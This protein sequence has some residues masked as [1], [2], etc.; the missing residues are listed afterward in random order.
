MNKRILWLLVSASAILLAL[1][2][3]IDGS[4]P[5]SAQSDSSSTRIPTTQSESMGSWQ[6]VWRMEGS[7]YDFQALDAHTVLGA[8]AN[9][10]IVSSTDGGEYWHYTAPVD[11]VD[12]RAIAVSANVIWVA[13]DQGVILKS[14]DRGKTWEQIDAETT[15]AINDIAAIGSTVSWIVGDNGMMMHSED[16]GVNWSSATSGVTSSLNAIG[17]FDD[18]MHGIS[19]G[20]GGVILL[21]ADGGDAWQQK[22]GVAP[23][24]DDLKDIHI[25]G[26]KVWAVGSAGRIYASEDMGSTWQVQAS[27][28]FPMTRITMAPGQDQIGWIVGLDGRIART[29]NGGG[30]W[31]ANSGDEGYHLYALAL[32]D[33]D[34]V[35]TGGYVMRKSIYGWG[36]PPDKPSWFVWRS[37]NG[38][39]NWD[40]PITGLYPWFYNVTAVTDQD[41]YVTGQDLQIMK[42]RDGGYSWREIHSEL[43]SNPEIAPPNTDIRGLIFHGIS[44]APGDPEDCHAA[45]RKA[46]LVHTTDGGDTWS[47]EYIAG[48]GKAIYDIEMTSAESGVAVCRNYNYFTDDGFTW[49]GA[50]DNGTVRTHLDVDMIN[51]WQG[52]VS[53]KKSLFNY[54]LDAGRHWKG[55][56]FSAPGRGS[57]FYNSGVDTMDVNEDGDFDNTWLVGCSEAF[58]DGPCVEA[59][60]LFNPDALHPPDSGVDP[61]RGWRALLADENV[62]RLQKVEMVNE[63]EGWV[64]GYDATVLFTEDAGITWTKQGVPTDANLYGLDVFNRDL[65]Y[66][67]GLRGDIIRYSEP[68]RRLSANPQWLNQIDGNLEEWNTLN[69]RNIN[70]EDVDTIIG[71]TPDP[72]ALDANVRIRWDDRG[73]YLGINVTDATLTTSGD[74]IDALGV[75]LD[76]RGDGVI[77]EDDHVLMF[78]ADGHA[79]LD[80]LAMAPTDFGIITTAEGYDIEAFLPKDMLGDDFEHLR[81]LGINVGLYDAAP[82]S[83]SYISQLFWTGTELA[84]D[85]A[86]FGVLTLFQFDRNHPT[87]TALATDELVI[88]GDLGDWTDDNTYPLTSGTADSIQGE[89]PTDTSDLSADFRMRWWDDYLFF[90]ISVSDDVVMEGDSV[91]LAFDVTKDS[92]LSP[93]DLAFR[94][95]P[96]GRVTTNGVPGGEILARGQSTEDGYQLEIALPATIL[97]GNFSPWQK[98]HFNYGLLDFDTTEDRF[99]TAMNW[100]G[101]SVAGVEAD[102]GWLE[103]SPLT[104]LF[105]SERADPLVHDTF[106]KEWNPDTNYD[107]SPVMNIRIDGIESPLI[108][109]DIDSLLPENARLTYAILGLYT[110]D[111]RGGAAFMARIYRMLRPWVAYEATWNRAG[112]NQAW[113]IP[114]AKGASDQAQSPTDEKKL[115]PAGVDG[116]CGDRNA[117]WFD[118]TGDVSDFVSGA[119]PNNGWILRGDAGANINYNL[120]STQNA[121]P[122]CF[123]EMYFEYTYPSGV[124]PS[125]TPV[126]TPTPA[127]MRLYLPLIAP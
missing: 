115:A 124:L 66:A 106:I 101:A 56:Y 9:G 119:A 89:F 44:C 73:L 60:I 68:D 108:R 48:W 82:D 87:Q 6:R 116:S 32:G 27:L 14:Q 29:S 28:G 33:D 24:T 51:S 52:A 103:L 5:S 98:L 69:S 46:L 43:T 91:L 112:T 77:G 58:Q 78:Y 86:T 107:R 10:M 83:T 39:A 75:A 88:D 30:S 23:V 25:Y 31:S 121:N 7:L 105:K 114:G 85:P 18:G 53:T 57:F 79:L 22:T 61:A 62:A 72:A 1:L 102:F 81:K 74:V 99:D 34:H 3:L 71:A 16:G 92:I 76:G 70:S 111:D 26:D 19:V 122:D 41:A 123:P 20:D 118:V 37:E 113:E 59:L 126:A 55:Y 104:L 93:Q 65:A 15:E 90:G 17:L 64:V 54:T 36:S 84:G 45:G 67:V 117:T 63:Q 35:W 42:T 97:G 96:D 12:L 13:G 120:A 4:K 47:R 2:F 40:A 80:G 38:G 8:G 110:T 49:E 50:F 125:P 21:T 127:P 95:W 11:G 94:I 109:F 100:Q